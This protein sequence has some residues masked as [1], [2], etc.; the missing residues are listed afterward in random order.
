MVGLTD[1]SKLIHNVIRAIAFFLKKQECS[2]SEPFFLQVLVSFCSFCIFYSLEKLFIKSLRPLLSISNK[3]RSIFR[4]I[5][6]ELF[7]KQMFLNI[8]WKLLENTCTGF[9]FSVRLQTFLQIYYKRDS[10]TGAKFLKSPTLWN[11]SKWLLLGFERF[12][13]QSLHR[14]WSLKIHLK[15]IFDKIS[16]ESDT[17]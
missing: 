14:R 5:R 1:F 8:S 4:I 16:S 9:S 3:W 12:S 17:A 10:S 11:F 6:P 15:T 13:C 7:Y 2:F